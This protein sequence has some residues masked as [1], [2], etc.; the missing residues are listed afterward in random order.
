MNIGQISLRPFCGN[1]VTDDLVCLYISL[2]DSDVP[3]VTP[4]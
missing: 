2:H 3:N 1:T 4:N